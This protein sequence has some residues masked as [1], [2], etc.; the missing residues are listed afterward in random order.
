LTAD[1]LAAMHATAVASTTVAALAALTAKA[2]LAAKATG[3]LAICWRGHCRGL[4]VRCA[5]QSNE[6]GNEDEAGVQ[7]DQ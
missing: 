5:G 7:H 3:H 6:R 1:K 4:L 2:T